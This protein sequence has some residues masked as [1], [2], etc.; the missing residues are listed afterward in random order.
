MANF[1]GTRGTQGESRA[2][3]VGGDS[4][5]V[6]AAAEAKGAVCGAVAEQG[7]VGGRRHIGQGGEGEIANLADLEGFGAA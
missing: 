1:D 7:E 2:R 3:G 4:G 6:A 5:G